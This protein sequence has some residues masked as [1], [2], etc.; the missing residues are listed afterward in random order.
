MLTPIQAMQLKKLANA[1]KH[2]DR[3]I[4]TLKRFGFEDFPELEKLLEN[5][6][7]IINIVEQAHDA[8][9]DLGDEIEI[10]YED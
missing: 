4:D 9:S 6:L 2:L 10:H 7:H 3:A 8:I 5:K 1:Q